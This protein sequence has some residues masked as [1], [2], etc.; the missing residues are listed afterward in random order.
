MQSGL[1]PFLLRFYDADESVFV[2]RWSGSTPPT[3]SNL[4]FLGCEGLEDMAQSEYRASMRILQSE[5]GQ[6]LGPEII[7]GWMDHRFDFSGVENRLAQPGGVAETIEV[8]SL[9]DS[10]LEVY[11]ALKQNLLPFAEHV[12]G[13]FSHAYPQGMSLYII[14]LGEVADAT[15]A[16]ARL[17]EIWN[18][19]MR[20][21]M[22]H[23]AA[24]SHHHGIGLAR[25]QFLRQELGSS[26]A[27]L[28]QVKN[29]LDP[30]GVLNPGK[31]AF[32]R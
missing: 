26:Y 3:G 4:F 6:K 22:Q 30:Q 15:T 28:Q 19:A 23:G 9:W 31:L 27:V 32:G 18:V 7:Q 25:Q 21:S 11:R 8:S 1:R 14:L 20:T 2:A 29:A 17:R 5:G 12:L 24:I 10:I 13:H 16:E